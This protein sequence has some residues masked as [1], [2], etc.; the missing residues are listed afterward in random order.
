MEE[1]LLAYLRGIGIG[2]A[3]LDYGISY[4]FISMMKKTFVDDCFNDCAR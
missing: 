4:L 1:K 3:P 2:T